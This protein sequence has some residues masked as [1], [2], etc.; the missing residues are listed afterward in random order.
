MVA[1]SLEFDSLRIIAALAIA[2]EILP[3]GGQQLGLLVDDLDHAAEA[4]DEGRDR[5]IEVDQHPLLSA[6]LII[7]AYYHGGLRV[8]LMQVVRYETLGL[9]AP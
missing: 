9:E 7:Q 1:N 5:R 2:T 6:R 8:I 3:A 4:F